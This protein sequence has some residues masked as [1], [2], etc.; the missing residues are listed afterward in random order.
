M[1]LTQ[2]TAEA[3]LKAAREAKQHYHDNLQGI[4][5]DLHPFSLSNHQINDS[6]ILQ[7]LLESRAQAF[8]TIAE[9]QQ[10]KDHKGALK[11]FRNQFSALITS[12]TFW[13]V[14]VHDTLQEL[15]V[16]PAQ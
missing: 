4:S 16:N 1:L 3:N 14:M 13:W 7:P 11:K 2:Q 9:E 6:E 12:V 10:I 8:A 5:D 15:G